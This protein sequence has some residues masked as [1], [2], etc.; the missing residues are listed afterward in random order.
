MQGIDRKLAF[1]RDDAFQ[2]SQKLI[3]TLAEMRD[4]KRLEIS[5]RICTEPKSV[6][7]VMAINYKTL[8]M[9]AGWLPDLFR[10]KKKINVC[11]LC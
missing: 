5:L 1:Y 2:C 6:S 4:K 9:S 8:Q 3:F 7:I 10:G 11:C